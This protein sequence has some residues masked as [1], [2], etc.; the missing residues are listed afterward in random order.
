MNSNTSYTTTKRKK[1]RQRDFQAMDWV[2]DELAGKLPEG[3]WLVFKVSQTQPSSAV[4]LFAFVGTTALAKEDRAV[5]PQAT[6]DLTELYP[7]T[8]QTLS[9]FS[10]TFGSP[11]QTYRLLAN[12]DIPWP[13]ITL[14]DGLELG[15]LSP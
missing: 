4:A 11:S 9:Y 15:C 3:D 6:W 14:S 5:D 10:Q 8:E 13:T 1:N 2:R 7:T 12:S